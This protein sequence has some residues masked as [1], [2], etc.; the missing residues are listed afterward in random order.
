MSR[1]AAEYFS[2]S[3]EWK[4]V[5]VRRPNSERLKFLE[6]TSR[7]YEIALTENPDVLNYLNGRGVSS[8][9][10][11]RFR[12]G[13]VSDPPEEHERYQGRLAIPI[14]KGNGIV[15][16]KFRCLRP[17]CLAAKECRGHAKF[18]ATGTQMLYNVNALD[19]ADDWLVLVEGE[20][21]TWILAGE[22]GIPT[23]GLPGAGT[24]KPHW[25]RLL[26]DIPRIFYFPD[27]DAH[28]D[29]DVGG[30]AAERVQKELP[31]TVIIDLPILK[32]GEKSDVTSV[33]LKRGRKFFQD[34]VPRSKA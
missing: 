12:L 30:E 26:K 9:T 19:E 6:E 2:S 20:P 3:R 22:C 29:K 24:W 16:F 27:R 13:F 8:A 18:L 21:D 31:Q 1:K 34:R 14:I 28:L 15:A 32:E 5:P 23:V 10:I 7:E 17:E 11:D 25:T 4:V 33:F